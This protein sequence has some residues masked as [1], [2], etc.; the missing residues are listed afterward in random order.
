M[1]LLNGNP[2]DPVVHMHHVKQPVGELG[3]W[4]LL[5]DQESGAVTIHG[6]VDI[7]A[8]AARIGGIT[9]KG[10]ARLLFEVDNPDRNQIEKARR[11]LTAL[12]RNGRLY[13]TE[14]GKPSP[15][16]YVAATCQGLAS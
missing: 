1:L 4:S 9:V 14:P 11:K 2:G 5:H 16:T 7:E 12:V 13:A 6:Q 15:T 8:V 10:A 3:P